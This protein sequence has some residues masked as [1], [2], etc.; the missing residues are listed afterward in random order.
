MAQQ[1][2]YELRVT[3]NFLDDFKRRHA[4][5]F[6]EVVLVLLRPGRRILLHTKAFYPTNVYRLPSGKIKKNESPIDAARREIYEETG[7]RPAEIKK[8]GEIM[9]LLRCDTNSQEFRSHI[10]LCSETSEQPQ[11][12]SENENIVEF[13][14][15]DAKE[16]KN[17][18][19]LLS[20]LPCEWSSWGR[21]RAVAH[22]FVYYRLMPLFQVD[23]AD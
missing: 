19:G 15:I 11:P 13:K 9:Y 10:F 5:K 16:L 21:L 12:V 18:A 4:E 20:N 7:L 14:E 1:E 23:K 3:C 2:Y 6:E 17:I 8:I 22:E